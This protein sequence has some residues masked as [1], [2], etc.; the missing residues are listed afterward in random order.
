MEDISW[1]EIF[2]NWFPMLLLVGVW[3]FFMKKMSPKGMK[4]QIQ[5]LN[6]IDNLTGQQV[7]ALERIADALEKR[8]TDQRVGSIDGK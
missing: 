6:S 7:R 2:V 4:S 8:N 1:F 5:Y 3:A